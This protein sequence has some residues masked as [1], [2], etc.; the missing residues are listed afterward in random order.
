MA[1]LA[2]LYRLTNLPS[3][4]H[5]RPTAFFKGLWDIQRHFIAPLRHNISSCAPLSG[6]A[7][8][9]ADGQTSLAWLQLHDQSPA[10]YGIQAFDGY[11]ELITPKTPLPCKKSEIMESAFDHACRASPQHNHAKVL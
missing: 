11:L 2:S 1:P 4:T 7:P 9:Q 6:N 5:C 10:S 8:A 3:F